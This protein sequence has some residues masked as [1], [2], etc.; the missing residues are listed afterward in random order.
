[1]FF[2]GGCTWL[3]CSVKCIYDEGLI[4]RSDIEYGCL[5]VLQFP[6]TRMMT[7]CVGRVACIGLQVLLPSG[8][9][10]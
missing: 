2:W 1:M 4:V 3:N 8:H 7:V 9:P 6:H 10:R 5:Q